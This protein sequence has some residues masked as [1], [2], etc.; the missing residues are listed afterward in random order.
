MRNHPMRIV[1]S[2]LIALYSFC[3]SADDKQA[4]RITAVEAAKRSIAKTATNLDVVVPAATLEPVVDDIAVQVCNNATVKQADTTRIREIATKVSASYF[5]RAIRLGKSP[6]IAALV[7]DAI[8]HKLGL[9]LDDTRRYGTL[10]VSCMYSAARV[11]VRGFSTSCGK[12]SLLDM[13]DL[14]VRVMNGATALC[15]AAASLSERQELACDCSVRA[16]SR[17]LPLRM[18]C[19]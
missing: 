6:E 16:G 9:A 14:Q 4:C 18:M 19:K 2:C 5:E 3:A 8:N 7:E 10:T 15:E 13:G 12:R 17:G 11:Q 1:L